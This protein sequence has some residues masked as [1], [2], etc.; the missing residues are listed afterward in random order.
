VAQLKRLRSRCE[1]PDGRGASL[2][3]LE[4]QWPSPPERSKNAST[5]LEKKVLDTFYV[6]LGAIALLVGIQ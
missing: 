5:C 4:E 1:A 2:N 6:I 3:G